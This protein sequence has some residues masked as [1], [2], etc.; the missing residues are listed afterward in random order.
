MNQYEQKTPRHPAHYSQAVVRNGLVYV[1]G[2]LSIDPK[3][4]R[5]LG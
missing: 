5:K 4:E 3:R 2:Q 1:S